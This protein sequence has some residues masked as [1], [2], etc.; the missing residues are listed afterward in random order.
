MKTVVAC[1]LVFGNTR[2]AKPKWLTRSA[3]T[4]IAHGCP[5]GLLDHRD[6]KLLRPDQR[7]RAGRRRTRRR[8]AATNSA[9][10]V[11]G[12]DNQHHPSTWSGRWGRSATWCW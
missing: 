4:K 9:L 11:P 1:V 2:F 5:Q 10:H 12:V 6:R 3:A 7:P 8:L